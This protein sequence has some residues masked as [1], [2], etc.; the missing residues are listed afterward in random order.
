MSWLAFTQQWFLPLQRIVLYLYTGKL[1][2]VRILSNRSLPYPQRLQQIENSVH[3]T[4]SKSLD[5]E[6]QQAAQEKHQS[7][8][9]DQ[10]YTALHKLEF[11]QRLIKQVTAIRQTKVTD[12]DEE[13]LLLFDRIWSRLVLQSDD[14]RE[15]RQMISKRWKR[16]GFQVGH[17]QN[18]RREL[19]S[20][21][22]AP[23]HWRISEVRHASD[24]VGQP[25]RVDSARRLTTPRLLLGMGLLGLQSIEYLSRDRQTCLT[26]VNLP[27]PHDYSF[28]IGVI[29]VVSWLVHLLEIESS[30]GEQSHP[31]LTHFS[32]HPCSLDEFFRLFLLVFQEWHQ[33]WIDQ[34]ASIMQFEQLSKVFRA[35]L[36]RECQEWRPIRAGF[37]KGLSKSL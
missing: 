10:I 19:T 14:D 2:W 33:Y 23:I 36:L 32:V 30:S 5:D 7:L 21:S 34:G 13:H 15:E 17:Q 28:A 22:R 27:P 3:F 6:L 8:V 24:L 12:V 29:N 25:S 1:E 16:I 20:A 4:S 26:Y 35:Q 9:H 11:Y 37:A 18:V 31:L